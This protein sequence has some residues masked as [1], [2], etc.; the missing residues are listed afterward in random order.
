MF[1]DSS[2]LFVK[3]VCHPIEETKPFHLSPLTD[4]THNSH[5]ALSGMDSEKT[6]NPQ[7]KIERKEKGLRQVEKRN[8]IERTGVQAETENRRRYIKRFGRQLELTTLKKWAEK[9][10]TRSL[11]LL[12]IHFFFRFG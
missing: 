2:L 10:S 9:K 4:C 5:L 7:N 1:E 12:V 6:L 11:G 8:A 3:R